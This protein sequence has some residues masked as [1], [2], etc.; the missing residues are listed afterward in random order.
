[1]SFEEKG[2]IAVN[3]NHSANVSSPSASSGYRAPERNNSSQSSYQSSHQSN[4]SGYR[5]NQNSNS[6][7]N[8]SGNQRNGQGNTFQRKPE[9]DGPVE[10][11]M[12]YVGTGNNTAPQSML[13][14]F[15]RI[16][17]DLESRGYTLRS[18]GIEGPEDKFE[19]SCTKQEIHLPWKGFADKESKFS[20]TTD[21]AKELASKFHPSWEGLKPAMQ[22]FLAKNVR[23]IMGKDL[24]SPALF[25][26]T[27]SEDGAETLQEKTSRTGNTGH[28]I[29]IACA[30]KIP[31][32]NFG[33]PETEA[34][35]NQYI[36][37]KPNEQESQPQSS[38]QH[39]A[40]QPGQH[41]G[42]YPG[43]NYSR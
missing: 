8:Y 43:P 25:M 23:M 2:F 36:G 12:P 5:G 17:V 29:A 27:W 42:Q 31:I 35:F 26:I 38:G 16:A 34:R 6:Y 14:N 37:T 22:I 9:F 39:N 32:F 11:Y 7:N 18:G 3:S 24:K 41:N 21:A 15:K 19:R 13:D 33:K 1:M 40:Q 20:F 28:A 10:L 4:S 30:L